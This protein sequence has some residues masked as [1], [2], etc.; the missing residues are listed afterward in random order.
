MHYGDVTDA[1]TTPCRVE[2][3]ETLVPQPL[4]SSKPPEGGPKSRRSFRRGPGRSRAQGPAPGK[5]V[6]S[7][8][9]WESLPQCQDGRGWEIS[10]APSCLR[11]KFLSSMRFRRRA[12]V[13]RT[14][15]PG[16]PGDAGP[17]RGS[18]AG[19]GP[20]RGVGRGPTGTVGAPPF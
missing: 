9:K 10:G 6:S 19:A 7:G 14:P 15:L 18:G 4:D 5:T 12:P 8:H 3:R 13:A 17:G 1:G 11:R 20:G 2:E 16:P